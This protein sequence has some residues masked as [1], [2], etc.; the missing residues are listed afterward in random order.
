M[1]KI[2]SV[3]ASTCQNHKEVNTKAVK[4]LIPSRRLNPDT[5][6]SSIHIVGLPSARCKHDLANCQ[7]N[8]ECKMGLSNL[9][10]SGLKPPTL[11]DCKRY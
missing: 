1:I 2:F 10:Y 4:N 8:F 9:T 3:T 11:N 6:K 5:N 7:W